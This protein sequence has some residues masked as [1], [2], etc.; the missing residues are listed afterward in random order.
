MRV[1][2]VRLTVRRFIVAAAVVEAAAGVEALR[3]RSE[4]FRELARYHA[5][6]E[7][8]FLGQARLWETGT[9]VGCSD[10]APEVTPESAA[11]GAQRCRRRAA[12]EAGLSR[13][14]DRAAARP[15]LLVAP[16][17]PAPD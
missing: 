16:D 7:L 6:E 8:G 15:W 17:P 9:G 12:Y 1:P 2:G 11:L 5:S 14:Y 10:V 13:K 3:R 4:G